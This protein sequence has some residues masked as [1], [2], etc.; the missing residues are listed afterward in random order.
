M[1]PRAWVLAAL[2]VGLCAAPWLFWVD[3]AWDARVW[4]SVRGE[5][6]WW[7]RTAPAAW[8]I[9]SLAR[10]EE[11]RGAGRE[12]SRS[13]RTDLCPGQRVPGGEGL[14]PH[15]PPPHFLLWPR[16]GL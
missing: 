15:V 3:P 7:G 9:L 14:S 10:R 13:G 5:R 8:F 12:L 2:L 11:A 16:T 4:G 6:G 1:D